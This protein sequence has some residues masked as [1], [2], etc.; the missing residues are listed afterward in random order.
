MKNFTLFFIILI[1]FSYFLFIFS[2]YLSSNIQN[3]S[4]IQKL[5]CK[6]N[7]FIIFIS[8]F[9]FK[10]NLNRYIETININ[11]NYF[12]ISGWI[13]TSKDSQILVSLGR[14]SDIHIENEFSLY[15]DNSKLYFEDYGNKGRKGFISRNHS[16]ITISDNIWHHFIFIKYKK[17]GI[18]YIDGKFAGKIKS[19]YINNYKN[20]ALCIGAD[21]RYPQDKSK[22]LQGMMADFYIWNEKLTYDNI[23]CLYNIPPSSI[24]PRVNDTNYNNFIHNIYL[25]ISTKVLNISPLD[26]ILQTNNFPL[27]SIILEFG[28]WMGSSI[29][30][31]AKSNQHLTIY[32]F[33]SFEGLP[34]D[35]SYP[36]VKGSFNLNGN[37]PNVYSNVKLFKGLFNE[38]LPDFISN[39]LIDEMNKKINLIHIDCDLYSSSIY[40]LDL[41][42]P[43]INIGTFIVFDELI[44]FH[45]FE[46]F[47]LLAFYEIINKYNITYQLIGIECIGTC[48]AVAIQ[49]LSINNNLNNNSVNNVCIN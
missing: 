30:R 1:L 21:C 48:Q 44:N 35:W 42:L 45:E 33:D 34:E 16:N 11:Y 28:V 47:E 36:W 31:I 23:K 39:Y 22:Y 14:I 40:V 20:Y 29:N 15:I 13:I 18:F 12:T 25:Q 49:I 41:L 7:N 37:L 10:N 46:K 5:T 26:Y 38:T 8:Y 9:Q 24:F 4:E 19:K 3:S 32:G 6:L 43:F 17:N 2:F 27:N